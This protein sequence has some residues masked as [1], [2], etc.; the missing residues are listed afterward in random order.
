MK[1][2]LDFRK[3]INRLHLWLGVPSALILFVLC[4][5]GTVY[6][7]QKEII[8]FVDADKYKISVA[9]HPEHQLRMDTLI[10]RVEAKNPDWWVR[11]IDIPENKN[12]KWFFTLAST[13]P[14]AKDGTTNKLR[15]LLVNPY[16]GSVEASARTSTYHFFE[17]VIELHR[18]LL[19]K[20]SVGAVI[21]V[22]ATFI[23]ILLEITGLILW[24]PHKLKQWKKW[25]M[26]KQG[27][28]VK[29]GAHKKRFTYDLHKTLGF[30]S[31]LLVTLM[32]VT[33]PHF[34]YSWY[35]DW[36]AISLGAKPKKVVIPSKI[37]YPQSS[38][39]EKTVWLDD[40][41]VSVNKQFPYKGDL[42]VN[43]PRNETA[44]LSIVKA[45]AGL[46]S[47][48]GTDGISFDQNNGKLKKVN[49]FASKSTGEKVI[50]LMRGLHT[51]EAFGLL[52]KMLYFLACLIATSLPMTGVMIWLNK[53]KK[54]K[55]PAV[56]AKVRA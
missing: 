44:V 56:K 29:M 28:V 16:T 13:Q 27:L 40:A 32:A 21:T 5:T 49:T 51:G 43:F 20:H 6:V 55:K 36:V 23:F 45:K 24:L 18:W 46:F 14:M 37:K 17:I 19:L 3:I 7:F 8:R 39:P 25:T 41:V 2:K 12:E 35:R 47:S 26:W 38:R 9:A 50:A 48:A 42:R 34:A 10:S 15:L 22:T 4:L 54:K 31:F 33:A 52:T 53:G 11:S 1:G 30:Y